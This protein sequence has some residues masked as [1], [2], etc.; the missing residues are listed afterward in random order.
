MWPSTEDAKRMT[1]EQPIHDLCRSTAQSVIDNDQEQAEFE[2]QL[3][4]RA[5]DKSAGILHLR[6]MF[7]QAAMGERSLP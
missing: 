1:D 5:E 3:L 6:S 2:Q 4:R 7:R